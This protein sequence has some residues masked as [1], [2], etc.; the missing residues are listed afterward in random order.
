MGVYFI[1]WE[2]RMPKFNI[3][4]LTWQIDVTEDDPPSYV[5]HLRPRGEKTLQMQLTVRQLRNL[6]EAIDGTLE[7]GA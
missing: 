5:V 4:N 6:K 3:A 2:V 7:E 1:E